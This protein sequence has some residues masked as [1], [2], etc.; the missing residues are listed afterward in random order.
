MMLIIVF[1]MKKKLCLVLLIQVG[2]AINYH[3]PTPAKSSVSFNQICNTT[4]Q[5]LV[6]YE[7]HHV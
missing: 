1:K 4:S 3:F 2:K 6:L 7:Y 5:A